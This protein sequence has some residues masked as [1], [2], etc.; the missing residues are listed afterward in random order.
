MFL[1]R[2]VRDFLITCGTINQEMP[3]LFYLYE[4]ILMDSSIL[5]KIRTVDVSTFFNQYD[6]IRMTFIYGFEYDVCKT[7]YQ[8]H[9]YHNVK[10]GSTFILIE[11]CQLLD[12]PLK[13]ITNE[14]KRML[15]T[16]TGYRLEKLIVFTC[17]T[18]FIVYR[19]AL[20]VS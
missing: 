5:Q 2:L 10:I 13:L 7:L 15:S 6:I 12:D 16:P 14:D 4:A 11:N 17:V 19:L 1:G 3:G 8:Y 20:A 9:V 18:C